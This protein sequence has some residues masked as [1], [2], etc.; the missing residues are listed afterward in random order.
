VVAGEVPYLKLPSLE[1][2]VGP[3]VGMKD[4]ENFLRKYVMGKDTFGGPFI[5]G[6]RWY[7]YRR[8]RYTEASM[9]LSDFLR[10][11]R[12]PS[13]LRGRANVR[14][15]S[16]KEVASLSQWALNYIWEELFKEEFFIKYL[17]K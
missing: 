8:R 11:N 9:L 16:E 15:L 1:R 3:P 7:V 17:V 4:E 6:D 13:P 5:E 2:R 12:M 14:I 10:S